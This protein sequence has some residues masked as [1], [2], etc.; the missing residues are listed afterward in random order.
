MNAGTKRTTF[1]IH[2][3]GL[4]CLGAATCAWGQSAESLTRKG[5]ELYKRGEFQQAVD[6][7]RQALVRSP[8]NNAIKYNLGTALAKAERTAEAQQVLTESAEAP[9]AVRKRDSYYNLGTALGEAAQKIADPGA[10]QQGQGNGPAG[11]QAQAAPMQGGPD[12]ANALK[13]KISM[14]EQSLGSLRK[15]ILTDAKDDYAKYN[16]ETVMEQL[17]MLRQMQQQM[18]QQGQNQNQQNQGQQNQNQQGGKNN[19]DKQQG[20]KQNQGGKK[21]QQQGGKSQAQGQ[22]GEE[23]DGDQLKPEQIDAQA[24]LN[25]LE[26][27]KPEQFKQLFRERGGE[28]TKQPPQKNW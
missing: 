27:E 26:A 8:E 1:I 19:K 25:L 14:L 22:N 17:R 10:A 13:Q 2:L 20:N 5:N 23:G 28:G 15:S 21:P 11:P 12:E 9:G 6:A 16:Y 3:F 24:L 4:A 7:Y 18:Q